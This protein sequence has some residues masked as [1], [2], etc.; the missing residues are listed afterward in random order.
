MV[1]CA[2]CKRKMGFFEPKFD[3]EDKNGNMIKYC[4]ECNKSYI[5]HKENERKKVFEGIIKK[6]L[7]GKDITFKHELFCHYK[8]RFEEGDTEHTVGFIKPHINLYPKRGHIHEFINNKNEYVQNH[9]YMQNPLEETIEFYK[10]RLNWKDE[11]YYEWGYNFYTDLKKLLLL[12]KQKEAS[13]LNDSELALEVIDYMFKVIEP[14]VLEEFNP[15]LKKFSAKVDISDRKA[16]V[17]SAVRQFS[18]DIHKSQVPILIGLLFDKLG[19]VDYNYKD[20]DYYIEEAVKNIDLEKFEQ[21]LG[22]KKTIKI[23]SFDNL[24]GHQFEDYLKQL[25]RMMGYSVER[26][27][28]S[29]DQGADLILELDGSKIVVQA[30]NHVGAVGNKAIQEIVAAKY[31]YKADKAIVICTSTYTQSAIDL[32]RSNGVELWDRGKLK[33]IIN[34]VN[35]SSKDE[36]NIRV[37]QQTI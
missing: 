16:I 4:K 35:N 15:L 3:Y 30:K 22:V 33:D 9:E 19:I 24:N 31:H 2:R 7:S 28:L 14:E 37:K 32:A 5:N 29:G 23:G 27:K 25:F 17:K 6:Y 8:V 34:E 1:N 12:I 26:T 21:D 13:D 20:I 36:G 11:S 18:M 10:N